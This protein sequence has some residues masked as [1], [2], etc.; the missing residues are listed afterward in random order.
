MRL[1]VMASGLAVGVA[2][3]ATV[4]VSAAPVAAM[5]GPSFVLAQ[6]MVP[7]TGMNDA[8]RPMAAEERMRRRFPQPVRVG[9]LIG[10]PV[11]DDGDRTVG[12]V[13]QVVRTR[14][15][16]IELIV[17]YNR[18]CG[19][20]G[21]D[22]RSVAVPIEVV[23]ILGRELASLDMTPGEYASAPTWQGSDATVLGNDDSVRV[24]LARR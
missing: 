10:L 2:I 8:D 17:A 6:A 4:P 7:P 1:K 5:A 13:R 21:F 11:L 3:A 19:W 12:Y 18:W 16:K 22:G 15:D 9:D 23:G 20:C 14:Q 24:A